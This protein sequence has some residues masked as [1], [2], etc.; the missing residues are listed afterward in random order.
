[1][2]AILQQIEIPGYTLL[3]EIYSGPKFIALQIKR[4]TD[5]HICIAKIP[6]S[7]TISPSD[8]A[9]YEREYDLLQSLPNESIIKPLD[10]VKTAHSFALI[11]EYFPSYIQLENRLQ[12]EQDKLKNT[13]SRMVQSSKMSALGEMAGGIAHEINNPLG[14]ITVRSSQIKRLLEQEPLKKEQ[15]SNF[16]EIIEKTG[17]QIAKIVKGLRFFARTSEKDPVT[18]CSLQSILEDTLILCEMRLKDRGVEMRVELPEIPVTLEC[19]PVQLSQVILNLFNNATDAIEQL[20]E[21]WITL[22]VTEDAE[23]TQIFITDSG[24][25][26]PKEALDK[27]FQPFFTT[28]DVDKGTGLGLSISRGIIE[29]IHGKLFVDTEHANTRFVIK[30]PKSA[31]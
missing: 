15:I 5:G 9:R 6:N 30:L 19:R 25:G 26:V 13:Q 28:K 29:D 18:K 12:E 14:V 22:S 23:W 10:L 27:I 24:N 7:N 1:M 2:G 20:P 17:L 3:K 8:T 31:L 16:A 4:N 11:E 21:K